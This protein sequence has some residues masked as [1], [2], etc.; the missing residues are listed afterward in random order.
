MRLLLKANKNKCQ[1]S[2]A[3]VLLI[4][5]CISCASQIARLSDDNGETFLW[6]TGSETATVYLLGSVH[7]AKE[8]LY[9]LNPL[10]ERAFEDSDKLALEVFMDQKT[11]AEANK[12]FRTS[13]LYPP[14]DS[15]D[16]HIS[17]E[18]RRMLDRQ[19]KESGIPNAAITS[20]KPWFVS[21]ILSVSEMQK[22][23]FA[24][25]FGI[26]SYFQKKA[27]DRKEILSLETVDDQVNLFNNI[28]DKV[29]ELMLRE[30]LETVAQMEQIMRGTMEAWKKGDVRRLENLMLEPMQK[31]EYKPL[32][33][34]VLIRRNQK[35][36]R[37]IESYLQ[38]DKTY[39]VIVGALHLVG[40]EGI[41]ELLRA[42]GYDVRQQ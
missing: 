33:Q 36:T 13:A 6:K 35:M 27:E 39:F 30:S 10:I 34:K 1:V 29:Q 5:L 28:S 32:L 4:F 12:K 3:M 18:V 11:G 22:L 24:P 42:R 21:M 14:G 37:K 25:E 9:P 26:D 7:L 41:V 38:T 19:L 40:Q 23:G 8:D 16:N 31:P 15:L 2:A 17:D 20:F